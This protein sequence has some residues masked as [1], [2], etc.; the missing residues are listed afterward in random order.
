MRPKSSAPPGS[1]FKSGFALTM[2]VLGVIFA[3]LFRESFARDKVLFSNDNPIGILCANWW[4]LPQAFFGCWND[5]NYLGADLGAQLFNSY[6][7]GRLLLGSVVFSKF[8]A[9]LALLF[10]GG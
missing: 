3:W 5:L 1:P 8:Y 9:P 10:L 7:I 4:A 6:H 2:L